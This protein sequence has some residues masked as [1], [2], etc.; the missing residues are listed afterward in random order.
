MCH[1]NWKTFAVVGAAAVALMLVFGIN[2]AYLLVF[3]VCPLM[4]FFMMKTMG[5]MGGGQQRR[6]ADDRNDEPVARG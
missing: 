2:P 6:R 4:M 3:A 1:K 5:G